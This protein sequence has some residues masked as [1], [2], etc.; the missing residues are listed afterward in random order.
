MQLKP[1]KDYKQK[2]LWQEVRGSVSLTFFLLLLSWNCTCPYRFDPGN[3]TRSRQK[4]SL[5]A[6]LRLPLQRAREC[7]KDD[8][9]KE[10]GGVP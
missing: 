10:D 2:Q 1:R 8:R 7:T 6:Y 9:E 3:A 5:R 4:V